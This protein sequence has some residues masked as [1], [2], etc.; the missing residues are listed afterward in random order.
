[1]KKYAVLAKLRRR[2]Q[3]TEPHGNTGRKKILAQC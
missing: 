2:I 1:L 3:Q